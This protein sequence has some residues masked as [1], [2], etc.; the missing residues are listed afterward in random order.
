MSSDLDPKVKECGE[1]AV[2]LL[3]DLNNEGD[4]YISELIPHQKQP[5]D[6]A[7]IEFEGYKLNQTVWRK[8]RVKTWN[9]GPR[10]RGV[11][12]NES[13]VCTTYIIQRQE[14]G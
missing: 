12:R 1:V 10:F 4:D 6:M 14:N 8:C 9:C 5:K 13:C 11:S 3:K 7:H 2:L